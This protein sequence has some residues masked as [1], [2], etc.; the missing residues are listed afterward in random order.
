MRI[1][2][3][4]SGFEVFAHGLRN[5]QEIAFDDFGNMFGVDNDADMPGEKERFV[6]I[7]EQSDSGWRCSHQYMKSE[8]RWMREGIWQA[9]T[10]I[11]AA[12]VSTP[13][14]S[15]TPKPQTLT[16]FGYPA[17]HHPTTRELLERPRRLRA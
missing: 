16:S 12:G 11:V 15:T 3:D 4:G 17:V 10:P 1:E 8:S 6:Y 9:Q 5:I 14:A 7:T 13:K 2:P